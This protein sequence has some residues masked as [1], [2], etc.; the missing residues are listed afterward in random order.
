MASSGTTATSTTRLSGGAAWQ[1]TRGNGEPALVV[2]DLR[3]VYQG[4]TEALKGVSFDMPAGDFLA[5]LGPNGAGKTTVIGILTGLVH[6][7]SGT[8]SVFGEDID[9]HH[10]A[11]RRHIGVVPQELNFNIFE[12]VIDIVVNQAG[13]YGIPRSV[14]LPRAEALLEQLSLHDKLGDRSRNLSGGMKRRLMIARALIH[15]PRLLIL[16]EPTAGVDVEL[17]RGMWDFLRQLTAGGTTILMTTHYLE[18]AEQLANH[19]AIINRGAIVA[20]GTVKGILSRLH[21]EA[22]T[23]ELAEEKAE[24]AATLLAAYRPRVVEPGILDI[25]ID[26]KATIGPAIAALEAAGIGVKMVRS[27]SGRLE[28]VFMRLTSGEAA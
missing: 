24:A 21:T 25:E 15:Q 5:L 11:A 7:S 22:V 27:K 9:R 14:A 20:D 23:V 13:Y 3:K 12:R 1:E 2:R 19:V 8:V 18:E 17:R 16:D 26:S 10:Q 4:G 28:E 6:K